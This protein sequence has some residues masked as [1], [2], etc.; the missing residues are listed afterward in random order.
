MMVGLGA[1]LVALPALFHFTNGFAQFG[2][3]FIFR[4]PV[5]VRDDGNRDAAAN[6]SAEQN[7]D[8]HF[9]FLIG[10]GVWHI[11]VWGLDSLVVNMMHPYCCKERRNSMGSIEHSGRQNRRGTCASISSTFFVA[12]EKWRKT[13]SWAILCD[14]F[15]SRFV[16]PGDRVLEIAAGYCEFINHINGR[17]KVRTDVNPDTV[18]H[19][20]NG[21]KV[22]P[23]VVAQSGALRPHTS[24][25]H[26]P[27]TSSTFWKAST[28]WTWYSRRPGSGFVP[29]GDCWCSSPTSG[30]SARATGTFADHHVTP[31]THL[32][33]REGLVKNGFE[34]ELLI[35]EV[36]ALQLQVHRDFRRPDGW[37]ASI[38]AC[39]RHSGI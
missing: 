3:R 4:L 19:A 37:Y 22:V 8:Q 36:P 7:S 23:G 9:N 30:I 11:H 39:A 29:A 17:E 25:L 26:L 20:S 27:V 21:V 38:F 24:T 14:D 33:L 1:V 12:K 35:P 32:S 2:T 28:T 6:Q 18:A 10:F 5:S 13:T 31:L 15:F 34:V 16:N